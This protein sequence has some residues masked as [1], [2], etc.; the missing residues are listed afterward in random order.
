[1]NRVDLMSYPTE[2]SDEPPD[3]SEKIELERYRQMVESAGEVIFTTRLNGLFDYVNPAVEAILG[4]KPDEV[5]GRHF[6]EF[7]TP[8][9]RAETS[10]FYD[11]QITQEIAR[12]VAEFPLARRSGEERWVKITVNLLSDGERYTGF[13]GFLRD[14]H[15]QRVAQAAL[16]EANDALEA[17]VA[18]R[19]AELV[20]ANADLIRQI[21]ERTRIEEVLQSE[22]NL[23]QTVIDHI[24]DYVYVKDLQSRFVVANKA[25]A[26]LFRVATT[27]DV[28]GH[29]DFDF[30]E[31][32]DA[33]VHFNREREIF[34]TGQPRIDDEEISV[35]KATGQN[36]YLL[37]SK[38]PLRDANGIVTGLVGIGRNVTQRRQYED[39]LR[40]Q[41]LF[42]RQLIDN[43]PNL[44]FVKDIEGRFRLVNRA[45][46]EMYGTT[47]DDMIGKT[48]AD[49]LKDADLVAQFAAD[50]REV[51][52]TL[53]PKFIPEE[54]VYHVANGEWRWLQTNKLPFLQRDGTYHV[55]GIASD[56][57]ERRN[58][59]QQALA[60]AVERERVR[61]LANFIRDASHDFRTPLS[62]INTSLYLLGRS[63]DPK[64]QHQYREVIQQQTLHLG[65]LLEAM[66]KMTRLDSE[67]FFRFGPVDLNQ[68][69]ASI[70]ARE[71]P[72]AERTGQPFT[73]SLCDEPL[74]V[75]GDSG[76]L[77]SAVSEMV[78]NALQFTPPGNAIMLSTA[79]VGDEGVITV[80]DEGIGI[81]DADQRRV[82]ERFFRVDKAR[83]SDRGGVG[84]GLSIAEKIVEAHEGRITL[85][86][87]AGSGSTFRVYLPLLKDNVY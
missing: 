10:D 54:I 21:R 23:L 85:E 47:I 61:V 53:T 74:I 46:A 49:F 71:I 81:H 68:L 79:L 60:L 25:V 16:K 43:N 1:M 36:V 22:R 80:A 48:D 41:Q 17:R 62:T 59:E 73:H 63:D 52:T 83:S 37:S 5:V 2:P 11:A 40:E 51:I 35:N 19:T 20:Q 14:I 42:L 44:I 86:S 28:L 77:D 82:F 65:N 39:E 45:L 75:R 9:W 56:I 32:E 78:K 6:N 29:T 34:R 31:P 27:D 4:Y 26:D 76:E 8:A 18:E 15:E 57:T 58:V 38:V 64:R 24:P 87:V 67:H 84:L 12:T 69:V 55:L 33:A 13:L 70:Y 72:H 30:L 3:R 50:D 7:I 66:L